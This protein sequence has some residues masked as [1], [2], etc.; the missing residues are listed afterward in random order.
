MACVV[1]ARAPSR[2]RVGGAFSP[3]REKDQGNVASVTSGIVG[4]FNVRVNLL[5]ELIYKAPQRYEHEVEEHDGE[6]DEAPTLVGRRRELDVA[7]HD[8]AFHWAE[9]GRGQRDR[10]HYGQG[11]RF[12]L[13]LSSWASYSESLRAVATG[14]REMSSPWA[15]SSADPAAMGALQSASRGMSSSWHRR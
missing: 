6:E 13:S 7:G 3:A 10:G 14:E 1:L 5:P 2:P 8:K 12:S 11:G 4:P 15:R 9:H